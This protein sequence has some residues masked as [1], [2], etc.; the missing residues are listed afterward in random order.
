LASAKSDDTLDRCLYH[1]L[2]S[3]L[4]G[5]LHQ[6]D[7]ASMSLSIESRVPLLDYRVVEYLATVPTSIKVP[8]RM[9]K[10]LLR[11]VAEPLLP[12]DIVYRKD[13]GAFGVPTGEWFRGPL[14][15]F[16]NDLIH[17]ERARARGIFDPRELADSTVSTGTLWAA[18]SLELWFRLFIDEDRSLLAEVGAAGAVAGTP[19]GARVAA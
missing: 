4:P 14:K 10:G 7:R 17:S 15:G 2:R 18:M 1:D 19:I 3:Y 8:D 5:L 13:K 16:L 9:P 6:E 11:K 12:R